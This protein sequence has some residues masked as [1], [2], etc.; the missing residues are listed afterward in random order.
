LDEDTFSIEFNIGEDDP[1]RNISLHVRGGDEAL[2]AI[3]RLCE[4][5]DCLAFDTTKCAIVDFAEETNGGFSEWREY[6]D[7][8][9]HKST[10][11]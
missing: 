2:K 8:V 6:R 3:K 1:I 4:R 5:F 11:S 9:L 10:D 7:Q